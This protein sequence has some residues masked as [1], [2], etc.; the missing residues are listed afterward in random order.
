MAVLEFPFRQSPKFAE[1]LPSDWS[2][3]DLADFMRAHDLLR[4]NGVGVGMDRGL[5]DR[6]EPWFVFYD[7][8]SE[9]V[10]LHVARINGEC[11]LACDTLNLTLRARGISEL[12]EA[13][14]QEIRL[15]VGERARIRSSS[16]V[17]VHPAARIIMAVSAV[18]LMFK[19]DQGGV[20]YAAETAADG[21]RKGEGTTYAAVRPL[22]LRLL[23]HADAPA[24]AAVAAGVLLALDAEH[25]TISATTPA[26]ENSNPSMAMEDLQSVVE[27]SV[28]SQS[29]KASETPLLVS[30]SAKPA[31]SAPAVK[32]H[33]VSVL[34]QLS[35]IEMANL[36][37]F[38]E[39][40]DTSPRK[41]IGPDLSLAQS[42]P[43][44]EEL[45]LA[46]TTVEKTSAGDT[47][48]KATAST[49][50]KSDVSVSTST[51]KTSI[52][53]TSVDE[54]KTKTTETTATVSTVVAVETPVKPVETAV[55]VAPEPVKEI[56]VAA[57]V[58]PVE[59]PKPIH[60]LGEVEIATVADLADEVGFYHATA[61]TGSVG[62]QLGWFFKAF[63]TFEIEFT[64]G[65]MMIEQA[66]LAEQD[67]ADIGIWHNVYQDGSV[68]TVVGMATIVDDVMG[69]TV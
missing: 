46:V 54:T 44:D 23:D 49:V 26:P 67:I 4:R 51:Q 28:V 52:V 19:L 32:P 1:H 15:L 2:Q 29:D 64:K 8:A 31:A 9:D 33:L 7:L 10:F 68:V 50:V 17:V 61:S 39:P 27:Q 35:T 13:F 65:G 53:T 62:E 20:A 11:L 21:T 22:V 37:T 25:R 47:S 3:Q 12:I 55:V 41:H 45:R 42:S 66:G 69:F 48:D 34:P 58:L 6:H 18:F 63:K 38:V 36:H 16:N 24:A 5:S 14:E 59:P 57:P 43:A 30:S 40:V 56:V 60:M